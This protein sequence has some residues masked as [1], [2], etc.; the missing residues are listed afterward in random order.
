MS[1]YHAG[2]SNGHRLNDKRYGLW[3]NKPCPIVVRGSPGERLCDK[4]NRLGAS[5]GWEGKP[6]LLF[7]S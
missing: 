5:E 7:F 2:R 3:R 1:I 6:K 4:K